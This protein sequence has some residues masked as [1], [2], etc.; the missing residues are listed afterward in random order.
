LERS[1][2]IGEGINRTESK[3]K[4]EVRQK[5]GWGLKRN[6]RSQMTKKKMTWKEQRSTQIHPSRP[7]DV[8]VTKEENSKCLPATD[9]K[10]TN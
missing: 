3:Q 2:F 9:G 7:S 1:P 8:R 10:K 6:L 4:G 5:G